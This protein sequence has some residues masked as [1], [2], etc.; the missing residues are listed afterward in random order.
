MRLVFMGTPEFAVKS[1]ELI[2]ASRHNVVAVVTAVDK[3]RGRGRKISPSAVKQTANSLNLPVLQPANLKHP[4]FITKLRSFEPDL[5]IVVAFRILPQA[6]Y[7]LP[8]LGSINLHASFLP[9]YRG[10]AP[11]NWALINGESRTGVTIFR[12]DKKVDTGEILFQREIEIA[13]E[14]NFGSLHDKLMV[15]GAEL[16]LETI[17]ALEDGRSEPIRQNDSEASPAPKLTPQTGLINWQEPAMKLNNLIRGLAPYPGAYSFWE[18][19]KIIILKAAVISNDSG[20]K[21]GT[22]TKSSSNEGITIACGHNSLFIESLK[23]QGKRAMSSAEFVRGYHVKAG[24]K[25]GN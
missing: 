8:R 24:N 3:P 25:F 16:L 11:I 2:H 18:Q 22:I 15:R 6:V 13:P 17:D 14:D 12:L 1:L 5:N 20:E 4:E 21:P 10:A 7:S 23:P 19:Q 9:K